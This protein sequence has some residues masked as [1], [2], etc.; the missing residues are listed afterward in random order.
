LESFKPKLQ[1]FVHHNF[2]ARWQDM[3]LKS[4][5]DNFPN[6]VV[7]FVVDFV[8]NYSFEIQN[9]CNPCTGIGTK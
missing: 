4:C 8:E 9:E 3:M 2:V 1:F 6:D 7:V 5:L